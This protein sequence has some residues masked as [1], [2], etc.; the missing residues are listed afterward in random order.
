MAESP[1]GVGIPVPTPHRKEAM[2][3]E[4]AATV[5]QPPETYDLQPQYIPALPQPSNGLGSVS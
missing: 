3:R 5:T 1:Q 4:P 2:D